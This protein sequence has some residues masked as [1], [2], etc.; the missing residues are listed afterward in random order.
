MQADLNTNVKIQFQ[1]EKTIKI[2]RFDGTN[3][4][5]WQD[6]MSWVLIALN[7]FHFLDPK[8]IIVNSKTLS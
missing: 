2:D 4:I 6:R 1:N 3:Y 5:P 8:L 7:L